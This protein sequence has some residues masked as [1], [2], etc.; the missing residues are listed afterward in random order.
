MNVASFDTTKQR[1]ED[2][3]NEVGNGK[4]QLPDFQRGWVWDD[5][6][7]RDLI[8]SV[9]Q[10]FPIGAVMTLET[11]GPDVNFKPRPIEGADASLHQKEP[12]TLV[13][14]GQQRL[15]S[16]F[17]SL[18]AGKPVATRDTRGNG[19]RRWYYLDMKKCLDD[20]SDR[21]DAVFSIP[22]DG[23]VRTF[24]NEVTLDLS[25]SP[26]EYAEDMFPLHRVFDPAGW[27]M[28]YYQHWGYDRSDKIELFDKF[29]DQVVKR[30]Q[31]YQ[32]PVI[33]LDKETPKEAVCIVFE[34]VN[35]GG[36]SLTVFELL[37]ASFAADDFHL[38]E[39]WVERERRLRDAHPVLR[40]MEN[41]I[42]LQ[43]LTLLA[44]KARG[45]TVSCRRRDILR[46]RTDEYKEWA[47][48]TK[49]GFIEAAKFLHGQKIFNNRD[50]PYRTQLVPL[51]AILA[52]LGHE[53]NTEGARQK[54]AR[55]FW[56]GV[57]GEMYGG[58]T[59]TR[60]S[61]DLT[62]VTNWVR[63]DEANLPRTI[64][65][66][67]FQPN[68]LLT[69]RTRNSAAYKGIYALLMR[70]GSRDFLSGKPIEEAAFFDESIDIHHIFPRVW[71]SRKGIPASLF[72][73]IINKTALSARTNRSIGGRAPSEYL[74]TLERNAEVHKDR[75]DEILASHRIPAWTLRNDDFNRFFADRAEGLLERIESAIGKQIAREQGMFT[76]GEPGD[77]FDINSVVESGESDR[78][79]FKSSLRM[80]L[81]TNKSDKRMELAAL[82]TLAAFLNSDGGTL[83]I[84][85]AD[86]HEPVGIQVDGFPNEDS[87]NLHLGNIVNRSMGALAMQHINISFH[88]Y[89]GVRVMALACERSKHPVYVK[90]G[91]DEVFYIRAGAS[92]Q[93]LSI[94]D[95]LTY[96][97][98]RF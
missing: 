57:L 36:V 90:D 25:S 14:D 2:I 39:D 48:K 7:I 31:Q 75:M 87:M 52:D 20:D 69:L 38:R 19:I 47:D 60:F 84:G 97:T 65:D 17:Q 42:F 18:K 98:D 71:C 21:E 34:K 95:A 26:K 63:D 62:D 64:Q 22:E 50:I 77:D 8:A 89:R 3:L 29:E 16:L 58:A 10:S 28:G 91:N 54:I 74:P 24:Q 96:I 40:G 73:S 44:T 4:T 51:A 67:N 55:W 37:T 76:Q 43:A 11:G 27:R 82:K 56:C 70:D 88:E 81:Y 68:R 72:N 13:L 79:E 45:N 35:Q 6:H 32:I 41:T 85:V 12:D 1:V 80:N 30:F 33:E 66:A 23:I 78:V 49:Q 59:E 93:S 92:T 15:T 5:H 46:L 61:Q 9:S 53:A 83:I 86:N 94:G